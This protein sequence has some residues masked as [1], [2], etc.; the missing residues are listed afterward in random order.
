MSCS[1]KLINLKQVIKSKGID[2]KQIAFAAGVAHNVA[3][4]YINGQKCRIEKARKIS[5]FVGVDLNTL[6]GN[7]ISA[8]KINYTTPCHNQICPLCKNCICH[9]DV[10]LTGKA[11]CVS[12]NKVAKK[13]FKGRST[14]DKILM[15][16]R[17]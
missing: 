13:P 15:A 16:D 17:R 3:S 5:E 6:T 11:D 12:K 10:V 1:V 8:Q 7:T 14:N 2:F 4:R 9:N